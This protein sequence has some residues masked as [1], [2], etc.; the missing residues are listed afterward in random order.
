[1]LDPT[2]AWYEERRIFI[3]V[4]KG[5]A[6]QAL[7]AADLTAAINVSGWA[8]SWKLK[9]KPEDGDGKALITKTTS[10]GITVSGSY[11]A[12]AAQSTQRATV[13]LEDTDTDNLPPGVYAY[14]LKRT[15]A[16]F[17]TVLAFGPITLIRGVHWG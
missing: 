10:S 15:D 14:E 6:Y 2:G 8:L 3:G 9:R 7:D 5:Y 16:G 17:E 1:M 12:V 4:D 13:T 11:N